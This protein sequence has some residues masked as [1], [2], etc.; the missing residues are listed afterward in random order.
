VLRG[1]VEY[2]VTT[3]RSGGPQA[4]A[5]SRSRLGCG[6]QAANSEDSSAN[7]QNGNKTAPSSSIHPCKVSG[8]TSWAG[9]FVSSLLCLPGHLALALGIGA[10]TTFQRYSRRAVDAFRHT[11]AR[12][13]VQS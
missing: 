10:A 6:V 4:T 9:A 8:R 2:R 7:G 13:V 12:R 11:N 1:S 5:S 3:V